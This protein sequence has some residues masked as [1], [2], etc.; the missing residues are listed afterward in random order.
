MKKVCLVTALFDICRE[1]VDGRKWEDYLEW[2]EK[3]LTIN[4]PM[5]IYTEEKVKKFIEKRRVGMPTK[6]VI[7]K[8]EEIP[9][10]YLKDDL[11]NVIESEE[12]KINVPLPDRIECNYSLYTII[13]YSKFKWILDAINKKYIDSNLF[14]WVDA[15]ISRFFTDYTLGDVFPGPNGMEALEENLN[16]EFLIQINMDIHRDHAYS[17]E[18]DDYLRSGRSYV[19]GSFFGGSKKAFEVVSK[20]VDYYYSDYMI[21]NNFVNN[22]QIVLGYLNIKYPNIFAICERTGYNHCKIFNDIAK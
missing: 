3:T 18:G 19:C 22:E 8:L 20:E 21:K 14:F 5:V 7:Q 2:F 9:Y 1:S 12:F 4:C 11:D 16:D 17:L 6:I 10:Y 15:G 13:Q